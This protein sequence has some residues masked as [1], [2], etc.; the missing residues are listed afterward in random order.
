MKK[1]VIILV[2]LVALISLGT[3]IL[4]SDWYY[5]KA[6]QDNKQINAKI[7]NSKVTYDYYPSYSDGVLKARFKFYNVNEEFVN[8][9][10]LVIENEYIFEK[11]L[12]DNNKFLIAK[13]VVNTED[14]VKVEAGT[15]EAQTKVQMSKKELSKY[16]FSQDVYRDMF[17]R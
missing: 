10:M 3:G 12:L 15:Y 2:A 4:N 13:L 9:A 1:T 8:F 5:S 16:K 14:L 11:H 17:V 6:I 7:A